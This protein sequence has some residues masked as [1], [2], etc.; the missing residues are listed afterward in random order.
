LKR[1]YCENLDKQSSVLV[2]KLN[3]H[4]TSNEGE[5]M[6]TPNHG[7]TPSQ[8]LNHYTQLKQLQQDAL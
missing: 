8:S 5:S 7:T 3:Y 4:T 2:E 6:F 1:F